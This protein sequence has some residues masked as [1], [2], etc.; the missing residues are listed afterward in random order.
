MIDGLE[1][2][3]NSLSEYQTMTLSTGN[4]WIK[5]ALLCEIVEE[6]AIG[7]KPVAYLDLDLQFSASIAN[8]VCHI[9]KIENNASGL[10]LWSA[11]EEDMLNTIIRILSQKRLGQGGVIVIDSVNTLQG[12]LISPD[13]PSGFSV[14]N[15]KASTIIALFQKFAF[16]NSKCLILSALSRSRPRMRDREVSWETVLAGGRMIE[17]AS[18]II[19]SL[20]DNGYDE[21][22]N[23][24]ISVKVESV[25]ERSNLKLGQTLDIRL[26]N[27]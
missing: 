1:Q 6:L 25:S 27:L 18:D 22:G 16:D 8:Q 10:A 21:K 24:K 5:T 17:R 4:P 2:L 7:R 9:S 12:M 11:R 19:L 20:R 13:P 15:H 3:L 23:S 14:A 26:N